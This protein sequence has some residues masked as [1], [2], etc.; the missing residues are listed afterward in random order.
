MRRLTLF[1]L[2]A[3]SVGLL[4]LPNDAEARRWRRCRWHRHQCC[5][6]VYSY[7]TQ[8]ACPCP[9]QH[10]A[11]GTYGGGNY[12]SQPGYIAS[13]QQQFDPQLGEVPPSPDFVQSQPGQFTS[14]DPR[15]AQSIVEVG[16]FDGRGFE[17]KVISIEPGT[18]VQWTNRGE[19]RHTVSAR[20]GM[21][22]SGELEPGETFSFTFDQ[23][24]T[25]EYFCRP[26]ED[27]GMVGT[28]HVGMTGD[29]GEIG[30]TPESGA[31]PAD[32]DQPSDAY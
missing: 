7:H 11:A 32:S 23:S 14:S 19:Q 25:Y 15:P 27:M 24:G 8:Q 13:Q 4:A 2:L 17:P 26:H 18:T 12:E 28:I 10:V 5:T 22:E 30:N 1:A 31:A 16:A 6:P 20:D 21:F 3:A 9:S 29:D